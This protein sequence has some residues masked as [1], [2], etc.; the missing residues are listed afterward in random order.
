MFYFIHYLVS[1]IGFNF[2]ELK[3]KTRF[4]LNKNLN[5]FLR[6]KKKRSNCNLKMR[7]EIKIN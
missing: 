2:E 1:S 6:E 4:F 7:K 3:F 5:L